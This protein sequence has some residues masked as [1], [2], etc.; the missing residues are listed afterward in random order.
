MK[1]QYTKSCIFG[2]IFKKKFVQ[3]KLYFSG[4][5]C[6]LIFPSMRHAGFI[7]ISEIMTDFLNFLVQKE[8]LYRK[9]G[10]RVSL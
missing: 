5:G 7:I 8:S 1:M 6:I 10:Q 9:E 2:M 4:F 3:L